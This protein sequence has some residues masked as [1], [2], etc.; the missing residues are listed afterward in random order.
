[1][2]RAVADYVSTSRMILQKDPAPK[3]L[4]EVLLCYPGPKAVFLHRLAHWLYANKLFLFAR[5]VSQCNRALTLIEIH[6][7]ARLGRGVFIDHGA[8]VVIGET[9]VIGDGCTIYHGVTLG[10]V[11]RKPVKRHPTIGN[12]VILGAGATILGPVIIG[13][14]AKIAP[15]A[16][17]IE[18]IPEGATV[19]LSNTK[20][21]V[22]GLK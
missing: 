12:D 6:P 22:S 17:I 13:N 9:A 20:T 14:G 2:F 1:M 11:S 10:G 7:G 5:M 3:S 4:L 19:P 21:D 15:G 8:G 18:D 16:V